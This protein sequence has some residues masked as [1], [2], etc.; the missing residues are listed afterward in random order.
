MS[1]YYDPDIGR[2]LNADD[3][4]YLDPETIGGLNLYAYCLNNPIKYSDCSGHFP[5]LIALILGLGIIVGGA[6]GGK[7]A[8][9]KAIKAG[10]TGA[11]LFWSTVGGAILGAGVGL[12]AGGFI[13]ATA[14][15]IVGTLST[16]GIGSGMVFEVSALQAF[17]LGALAVDITAVKIIIENDIVKF[18][19][20]KAN[21]TKSI[22]LIKKITDKG[23]YYK[24]YFYFPYKNGRFIC[25]K[26]LITKG[27]I[28]DF[29][30]IFANKIIRKN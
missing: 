29:E 21:Y 24:F 14:G 4:N 19:N 18:E 23:D 7:H 1:R 2:F 15:V 28:H 26:S 11:D 30:M 12:A 3:V 8:Y 22:K 27:T 9:D 13:V 17:A 5:F 10:K 16:I 20:L 25:Q 6:L